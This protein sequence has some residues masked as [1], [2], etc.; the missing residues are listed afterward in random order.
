MSLE[1]RD[2]RAQPR[3]QHH[4][5]SGLLE[6]KVRVMPTRCGLAKFEAQVTVEMQYRN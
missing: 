5:G 4:L 6:Q 2:A 3:L 1:R